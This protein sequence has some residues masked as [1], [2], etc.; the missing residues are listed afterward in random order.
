MDFSLVIPC[1]NEEENIDRIIYEIN[2]S[3]TVYKY[4]IIIVDDKSTDNS[5]NILKKYKDENKILLIEN[6][7]NYGQ[8]F[9]LY[10]GI[11][12]ANS[13][14]IIT[15]DCDG[16]NDPKDIPKLLK[17][18]SSESNIKLVSGI[19]YKRIDS[20]LKIASSKIANYI[21]NKILKDNCM[22]TGCSLKIFDKKIFLEFPYFNGIHRFIPALFTG[23]NN[24]T[25]YVNVNHRARIHGYSKYGTFDRLFRGIRDI[26]RVYKI[27]NKIKKK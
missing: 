11:K 8:S 1:F 7:I 10:K 26:I 25:I 9:S 24:K 21:R 18:Y 5:L 2:N 3:I 22:D 14:I 16:Q 23:T 27:L 19:R 17:I 20:K 6:K 13:N 15:L 4:E 12:N